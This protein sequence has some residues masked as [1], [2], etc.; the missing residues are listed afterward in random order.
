VPGLTGMLVFLVSGTVLIFFVNL[1]F[2]I[3][4]WALGVQ[5]KRRVDRGQA[6]GR[7][8]MAVSG[9]VLGIVGTVLG[10]LALLVWILFLAL[11]GSSALSPDSGLYD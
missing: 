9:Q 6:V 4:A 2:S 8:G 11:L 7:R 10:A 1:P 3:A 5:A